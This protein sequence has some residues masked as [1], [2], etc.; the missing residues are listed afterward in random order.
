MV[1][2]RKKI[3]LT[4]IVILLISVSSFSF[5]WFLALV[6]SNIEFDMEIITVDDKTLIFDKGS[7]ID[8]KIVVDKFYPGAENIISS[9]KPSVRLTSKKEVSEKYNVFFDITMNEIVYSSDEKLAEIILNIYDENGTEVKNVDGLNY[10]EQGDV[11]GFDLTEVYG[12]FSI[13]L[14]KDI[15]T[16]DSI[17]HEYEFIISFINVDNNQMINI[18]SLFKANIIITQEMICLNNDGITLLNKIFMYN[19]GACSILEKGDPSFTKSAISKDAYDTYSNWCTSSSYC[20]KGRATSDENGMYATDDVYGTSYYYRGAVDNNWVI[21]GKENEKDIYWR[22]VRVEGNGNIKLIYSGTTP[23]KE[24][25][26]ISMESTSTQLSSTSVFNTAT[27]SYVY[28]GYVYQTGVLHGNTTNSTIKTN[29]DTWYNNTLLVDYGEFIDTSEYCIDRTLYVLSGSSI[30]DFSY[31]KKNSEVYS[32][33]VD[34]YGVT[35]RLTNYSKNMKPS[36]L[37]DEEDDYILLNVGLMSADEEHYAGGSRYYPNLSYYLHTNNNYWTISPYA[38]NSSGAATS[39]VSPSV[40]QT[41]KYVSV[42]SLGIRPTISIRS[43]SSLL[44]GNGTWNNP[45]VI[46]D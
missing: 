20:D 39:D 31:V 32:S 27:N 46:T 7:N 24:E 43:D 23:P 17:M 35:S 2:N 36:L 5:A 10:V 6:N 15:S 21:F 8:L 4:L 18:G 14:D 3:L 12:G 37:C 26:A 38:W 45:Y 33:G 16:S 44:S 28:S 25:D 22:I 11:R 19:G 29:V 34:F 9:T 40:T 41:A 13:F 42:N 30:A 1:K